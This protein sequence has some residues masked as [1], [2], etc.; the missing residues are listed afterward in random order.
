[1]LKISIH[2]NDGREVSAKD[3]AREYTKALRFVHDPNNKALAKY[4]GIYTTGRKKKNGSQV[5]VER[6]EAEIAAAK[7]RAAE[8]AKKEGRFA[9]A[10]RDV[11]ILNQGEDFDFDAEEEAESQELP[12]GENPESGMTRLW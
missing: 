9:P 11:T 3:F 7:K 4:L 8:R 12:R 6:D 2:T 5:A 1:M 10:K